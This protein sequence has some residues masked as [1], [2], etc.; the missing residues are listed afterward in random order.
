ML[1]LDGN[2]VNWPY[3]DNISTSLESGA[4]LSLL[5]RTCAATR[6]MAHAA[7]TTPQFQNLYRHRGYAYGVLQRKTG[8]KLLR[9]GLADFAL[10]I[11]NGHALQKALKGT[12]KAIIMG[13]ILRLQ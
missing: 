12:D 2:E 13:R 1:C 11:T 3:S 5:D 4:V 9:L 10:G 8:K 7:L 6:F